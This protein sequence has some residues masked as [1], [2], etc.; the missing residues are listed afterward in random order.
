MDGP[1]LV[2]LVLL[3]QAVAL[4]GAIAIGWLSTRVGRRPATLLCF[5]GWI[6]V[7]VLAWF[8]E[9][10]QQLTGLAVLLALVLGGIQSLLRAAIAVLAPAGHAGVAFGLL[11]VGTK[12][13]GFVAGLAFG[14]LQVA[15]GSPQSGLIALVVQLAIGWWL[16]RRLA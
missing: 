6:I 15:L 4:P 8:V 9:T 10:T 12:L 13:S 14:G 11:Q 5:G 7:L 1:A 16:I 2:R 3:V